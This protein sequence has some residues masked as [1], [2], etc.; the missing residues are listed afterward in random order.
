[1][2]ARRRAVLVCSIVLSV[3]IGVAPTAHAAR[4]WYVTSV[5]TD[6][7][8]DLGTASA[9][10][11]TIQHAIDC[12]TDGDTINVG[13][14]KFSGFRLS[15]GLVIKGVSR[16]KTIITPVRTYGDTVDV[17]GASP[18]T[19]T[20][21]T[22]KA[23][24]D[25]GVFT[26][27]PVSLIEIAVVGGSWQAH[28]DGRGIVNAGGLTL[29][30]STVSHNYLVEGCGAGIYSTGSL[31]VRNSTI[32]KNNATNDCGGGI[33]LRSGPVTITGSRITGNIAD[34]GGAGVD[35]L[36]DGCCVT[37]SSSTISGNLDTGG[38]GGGV[39]SR[40]GPMTIKNTKIFGNIDNE[41]AG[42]GVYVAGGS[43]T[44]IG[45]SIYSNESVIGGGIYSAGSL[46]L[47][48]TQV[49]MNTAGRAVDGGGGIYNDGGTVSISADSSVHDNVPDDCVGC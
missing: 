24:R 45:S 2:S 1:M 31:T 33:E 49:Y 42:G 25:T 28:Q 26:G 41:T 13:E 16:A 12:A 15:K 4:S 11:R 20:R 46:S 43:M 40:Y 27:G 6:G 5:G 14:G 47:T 19:L 32:T 38:G 30:A 18:E 9:P 44:I 8:C 21:V 48:S 35:N 17:G 39:Y 37:I 29:T 23:G 10:F 34:F 7:P 36:F 3:S 22:I